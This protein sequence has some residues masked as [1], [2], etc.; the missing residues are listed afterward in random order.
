MPFDPIISFFK[1]HV[2]EST[3]KCDIPSTVV[4][5]LIHFDNILPQWGGVIK[6]RL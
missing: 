1:L 5:N 2:A 4:S 3:L 6:R